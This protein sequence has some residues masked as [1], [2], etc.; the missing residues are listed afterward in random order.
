MNKSRCDDVSPTV[1]LA[2]GFVVAAMSL[3]QA[4]LRPIK[5][6]LPKVVDNEHALLQA[7]GKA[8][9]DVIDFL[10]AVSPLAFPSPNATLLTTNASLLL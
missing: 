1:A 6:V 8:A 3:L 2:Y 10:M 7:T 9:G 4:T 5:V